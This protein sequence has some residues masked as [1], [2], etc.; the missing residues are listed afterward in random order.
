MLALVA[1]CQDDTTTRM[2]GRDYDGWCEAIWEDR[3]FMYDSYNS[4][5]VRQWTRG[6]GKIEDIAVQ[7]YQQNDMSDMEVYLTH[8]ASGITIQL[9]DLGSA[10]FL[11]TDCFDDCDIEQF[12]FSRDR[13]ITFDDQAEL[14][15]YHAEEQDG[16][17]PMDG[18]YVPKDQLSTFI[19]ESANSEW[20]LSY[21]TEDSNYN[22]VYYWRILWEQSRG[23]CECGGSTMCSAWGTAVFAIVWTAITGVLIIGFGVLLLVGVVGAAKK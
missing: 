10:S 20:K 9:W 8:F 5:E 18:V 2:Y 4:F 6:A 23:N 1:L 3:L 14:S 15:Y 12:G 17:Y 13:P 11:Q 19:G 22:V 7:I 16:Y 21:Y